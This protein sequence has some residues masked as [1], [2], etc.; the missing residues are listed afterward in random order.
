MPEN[1]QALG[2]GI[3]TR[4]AKSGA[5]QWDQAIAKILQSTKLMAEG[6]TGLDSRL[7]T[8]GVTETQ[9][10]AT[11]RNLGTSMQQS[12]VSAAAMFRNIAGLTVGVTSFSGAALLAIRAI[13][14]IV[15]E[16]DHL[17]D[18]SNRLGVP[19]ETLSILSNE[20]R[21]SGADINQVARAFAD[22]AKARSAALRD[23]KGNGEAARAF[24][25][26]AASTGV[27]IDIAQD[28]VTVFDHVAKALRVSEDETLRLNA[29]QALLGKNG[30][31]LL[32][33]L[34]EYDGTTGKAAS[35]TTEMA[36]ASDDLND[37]IDNL[38]IGFTKLASKTAPA[39]SL[40]AVLLDVLYDVANGASIAD[41]AVN[42]T[43]KGLS[44]YLTRK[45]L[46]A[47]ANAGSPDSRPSS[48][49]SRTVTAETT[50]DSFLRS[51]NEEAALI[52][53]S[54]VALRLYELAHADA[55]KALFAHDSGL[56]E[57]TESVQ[58]AVELIE[59]LKAVERAK[60]GIKG[61]NDEISRIGKTAAEIREIDFIESV[62]GGTPEDT[63]P[64]VERLIQQFRKLNEEKQRLDDEQVVGDRLRLLEQ[65]V[66]LA[67]LSREE[68]ER[69]AAVLEL[70]NATQGRLTNEQAEQVRLLVE[71][72][73]E[74]ERLTELGQEFADGIT[75]G[76][77]NAAV[78]LDNFG[79]HARAIFDDIRRAAVRAFFIQPLNS[80]LAG[81]F[82]GGLG[83]LFG[84]ANGNVFQPGRG[85]PQPV[86]FANG[87]VFDSPQYFSMAGGRMGV[88]AERGPEAIMPLERDS[89]GRLGVR[90]K[91]GGRG[92]TIVN[93]TVHANDAGSFKKSRRQTMNDVRR[94]MSG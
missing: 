70:M 18:L 74:S 66:A 23:A 40:M 69:E 52:G 37:A 86:P 77:E 92:N 32:S 44:E 89:T 46:D 76:L 12:S 75:D 2:L 61:L 55:T 30:R 54:A 81:L 17:N 53:K 83:S 41:A 93:M 1:I 80:A 87:G 9:A 24:R 49:P 39:I 48:R 15:N 51:L 90:A 7:K 47:G 19:V 50:R 79:D 28:Q 72:R 57:F 22:L 36:R 56:E 60:D 45:F 13:R 11:A 68:R 5:E 8:L 16:A 88:M 73:Q 64:Q 26:L 29:A 31:T 71:A 14:G 35:I 78:E 25:D 58:G 85:G 94:M 67:K 91:G 21:Q 4:D 20:A 3:D 27:T 38:G 63:L 42:N 65:E 43:A 10:A 84:S 33:F 62:L 82:G 6:V 59:R 34:E